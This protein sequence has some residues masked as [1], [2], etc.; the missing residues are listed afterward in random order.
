MSTISK[1]VSRVISASLLGSLA[2][3]VSFT[4]L[5]GVA[6]A[7]DEAASS[8]NS[9]VLEEVTVTA[10]KLNATKVLDTPA[11]IQAISGDALQSQGVSGIMDVAGQIPGLTVQD[12]GPGDK[13][14]SFAVSTRPAMRP[15]A[16]T[17][18]KR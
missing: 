6:N 4:V 14:M 7:A 5:P 13:S 8:D 17:T 3:I 1:T 16:S 18:A 11:S 12:L 9:L 15:L 10:N 2:G